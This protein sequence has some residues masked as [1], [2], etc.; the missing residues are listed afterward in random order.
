MVGGLAVGTP[1]MLHNGRPVAIESLRVGNVLMGADS[2]PRNVL[3][4]GDGV[5]PMRRIAPIK[6]AP[7][8]CSERSNVALSGTGKFLGKTIDAPLDKYIEKHCACS[9]I[10]DRWKLTRSA[11]DFPSHSVPVDPYLVGL[12][13]GDGTF[14]EAFITNC[15]PEILDYCRRIAPMYGAELT[16]MEFP[17]DNTRRLTFKTNEGWGI[18]GDNVVVNPIRRFFRNDCA[19]DGAKVIPDGY[20]Y[21]SAETRAAILAGIIDTDGFHNRGVIEVTT[22]SPVLRDQYLY[23]A[24]SLGL[25][26]YTSEKIAT[27]KSIGFTGLYHRVNISGDIASLPC[28]VPRRQC[29][30][31]LQIKRVS[32]TGFTAEPIGDGAWCGVV[33]DGDGRFLLGDFTVAR[34][35][36]PTEL[37][38]PVGLP[39]PEKASRKQNVGVAPPR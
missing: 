26:A 3:A 14:G 2:R 25:A 10:D 4:T 8:A 24:R 34:D 21:N 15:E 16:V 5:G 36:A 20:L 7:W 13:I 37:R 39:R 27:I 33:L 32:V 11:V 1:V 12:W 22:V 31:R 17:E 28:I 23:L 38:I 35:S 18:A 6:G 29:A 19:R 30:D 9:R